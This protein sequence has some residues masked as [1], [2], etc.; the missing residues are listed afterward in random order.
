M[1]VERLSVEPDAPIV[2]PPVSSVHLNQGEIQMSEK[3][4]EVIKKVNAAF[5][6]GNTEDF[7]SFCAE[8]MKWTMVGEQ[9]VQGK[10][11]I[12]KWIASMGNME[13]PKF[14]VENIIAEGDFVLSN[15]DMTMKDKDGKSVP[16]S[17]CDIYR[18]RNGQIVELRSYVIKTEAKR[19]SSSGA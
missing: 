16:Y 6:K 1:Q 19:V 14:T 13:P 18:F 15:G 2:N 4:K 11:A 8:D 3:N 17:Y 10:D 12:R 9:A 7:L 5:T